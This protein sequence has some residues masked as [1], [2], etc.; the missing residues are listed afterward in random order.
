MKVLTQAPA[1]S[2]HGVSHPLRVGMTEIWCINYLFSSY[3]SS[4]DETSFDEITIVCVI[5]ITAF[6]YRYDEITIIVVITIAVFCYC[7]DEIALVL[8]DCNCYIVVS[9]LL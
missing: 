7:Y 4:Y 3:R 5:T 9:L 8:C 1:A 6:C 2:R